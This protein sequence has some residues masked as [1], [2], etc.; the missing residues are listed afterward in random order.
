MFQLGGSGWASDGGEA[1]PATSLPRSWATKAA[2][3]RRG[4]ARAVRR[5]LSLFPLAR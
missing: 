1:T 4:D 2:S 5:F 3:R